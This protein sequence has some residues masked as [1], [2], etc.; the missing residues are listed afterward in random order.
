MRT[1]KLALTALLLAMCGGNVEASDYQFDLYRVPRIYDGK[2][3]YPDFSGR[4]KDIPT[5]GHVYKTRRANGREFCWSLFHHSV[6]MR[7]GLLGRDYDGRTDG[8]GLLV[9][10][11]RRGN[12]PIE[13]TFAPMSSLIVA[14]WNNNFSDVGC[15]EEQFV[16][17]G[18]S[19]SKLEKK[20]LATD[21]DCWKE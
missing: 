3:R 18:S 13:L 1:R 15:V 20:H 16:W 10:F 6:R 12:W 21:N 17:R 7:N 5:F 11:R 9:S 4:D 19:F 14:R 2:I 8:R